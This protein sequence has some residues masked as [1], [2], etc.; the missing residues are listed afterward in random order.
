MA[1]YSHVFPMPR[2]DTMVD[3][4]LNLQVTLHGTGECDLADWR[5]RQAAGADEFQ[6][7]IRDGLQPRP[8]RYRGPPGQ[9]NNPHWRCY[10]DQTVYWWF[11]DGPLGKWWWADGMDNP[12]LWSE[13]EDGDQG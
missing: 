12:E 3:S 6:L 13:E 11:Y 4:L 9:E 5:E 1:E 10:I 7:L 2:L 8:V